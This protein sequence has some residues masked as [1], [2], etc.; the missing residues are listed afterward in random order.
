[1]RPITNPSYVELRDAPHLLTAIFA[2]RYWNI[3]RDRVTAMVDAG[4]FPVPVIRTG[5]ARMVTKTALLQSLRIT[6]SDLVVLAD[7]E[8]QADSKD[9]R[10]A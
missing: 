9:A 4:E 6:P 1:M 7:M 10:V 8:E 3:G 5:V 2:G